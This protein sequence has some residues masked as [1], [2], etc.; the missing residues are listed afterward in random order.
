MHHTNDQNDNFQH[1]V[2]L[3]YDSNYD[4]YDNNYDF[5]QRL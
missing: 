4:N 5:M 1:L 2:S 3:P